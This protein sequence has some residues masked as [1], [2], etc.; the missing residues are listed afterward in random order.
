MLT[1]LTA[2][3]VQLDATQGALFNRV[4]LSLRGSFTNLDS[5]RGDR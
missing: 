1:R 2:K 5:P 3:L 4:M